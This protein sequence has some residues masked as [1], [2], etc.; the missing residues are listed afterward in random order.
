MPGEVDSATCAQGYVHRLPATNYSGGASP[1]GISY[2]YIQPREWVSSVA[3]MLVTHTV[4]FHDRKQKSSVT[5]ASLCTVHTVQCTETHPHCSR[6][7]P[8]DGTVRIR[9][10]GIGSILCTIVLPVND[11]IILNPN[12]IIMLQRRCYSSQKKLL[13]CSDHNLQCMWTWVCGNWWEKMQV[14]TEDYA[15]SIIGASLASNTSALGMCTLVYVLLHMQS[16]AMMESFL[17]HG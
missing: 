1:C 16:S 9:N 3:C 14:K 5:L 2:R 8:R 11:M 13:K 4:Q 12:P 6:V 7:H 17:H 10:S 15:V